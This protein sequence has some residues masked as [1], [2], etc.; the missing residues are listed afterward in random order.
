MAIELGAQIRGITQRDVTYMT[1]DPPAP[2]TLYVRD[3]L[4]ALVGT[5]PEVAAPVFT[6]AVTDATQWDQLH[7]GATVTVSI[8]P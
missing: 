8:T 2:Q 5:P 3:V 7:V 1:G 4:F 6:I